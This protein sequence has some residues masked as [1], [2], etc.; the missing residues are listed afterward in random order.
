MRHATCNMRH[1]TCDMRHA[2]CD[3]RHAAQQRALTQRIAQP[4]QWLPSA[5]VRR[6]TTAAASPKHSTVSARPTRCMLNEPA[7]FVCV[8]VCLFACSPLRVRVVA[9]AHVCRA[10]LRADGSATAVRSHSFV[11]SD[12]CAP[13]ALCVCPACC[14]AGMNHELLVAM[15]EEAAVIKRVFPNAL[16]ACCN[17][18]VESRRVA[19]HRRVDT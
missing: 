8:F 4:L 17:M 13:C 9:C 14:A 11:V 16:K 18:P 5:C 15:R 6:S 10:R 7:A 12:V 2:T 19:L 3:M 1:A